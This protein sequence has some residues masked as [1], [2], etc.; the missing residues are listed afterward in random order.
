LVQLV[1][2]AFDDLAFEESAVV[3][4]LFHGHVRDDGPGFALNDAF[5]DVLDMV[6]AGCDGARALRADLAVRVAGEED[7]VLLQGSLVIVWADGED[8]GDWVVG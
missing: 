6:A 8:G 7:G 3:E 1:L 4:E 2:D 5:D